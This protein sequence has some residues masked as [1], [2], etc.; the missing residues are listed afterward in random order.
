MRRS[1][2]MAK[3]RLS[4]LKFIDF[5]IQTAG[6]HFFTADNVEK[7]SVEQ[8]TDFITEGVGFEAISSL[9]QD[10]DGSVPVYRFFN[11]NQSHLRH[12]R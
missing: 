5:S 9:N 4:K 1:A 8:H 7:V 12:L 6:G 3:T 2:F 11:K 10:A